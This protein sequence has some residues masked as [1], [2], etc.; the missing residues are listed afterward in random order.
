[1]KSEAVRAGAKRFAAALDGP[2][3]RRSLHWTIEQHLGYFIAARKSGATWAQIAQ[4]LNAA[5]AVADD[6]RAIKS[7]VLSA[8]MSRIHRSIRSK[9]ETADVNPGNR[10]LKATKQPKETTPPRHSLPQVRS[11]P[12]SAPSTDFATVRERMERAA[13]LRGKKS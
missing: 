5:G 4:A 3:G 1:M 2:F 9:G 13:E 6:G 11:P 7:N 10:A 8:T 12:V